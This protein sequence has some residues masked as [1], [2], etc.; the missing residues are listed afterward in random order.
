MSKISDLGVELSNLPH[1]IDEYERAFVD[2]ADNLRITGKTLDT[3]I[4][5]Q[6]TWPIY[7]STRR[8]ELKT[9]L[10]YMDDR[11]SATRGTVT[12]RFVENY[13]RS[14]GERVLSTFVDADPQYLK[15][16]ELYLEVE[17]LYNRYDAACDAFERRGYALRDL[18]NA[19]MHQL[20]TAQL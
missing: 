14:I 20:Q 4:K 13:S 1:L 8:A 10:K 17:D 18:T 5:E 19:R 11:V 15:V 7:Y 16:R 9:L 3:A 12:R 2:V 6:G